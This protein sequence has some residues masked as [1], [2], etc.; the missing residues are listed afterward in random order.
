M[1]SEPEPRIEFSALWGHLTESMESSTTIRFSGE[2]EAIKLETI[3]L[4]TIELDLP[5]LVGEHSQVELLSLL[6]TGGMGQVHLGQQIAAQR[7]VAVKVLRPNA[8]GSEPARALLREALIHAR[9]QHP[10]IVPVYMVG[11]D[12]D[13]HPVIVMKKVDGTAWIDLLGDHDHP[14]HPEEDRLAGHLGILMQVCRAAHYA[15]SRG[16]VHRDIKPQNVMIGEFGEVYVLDWGLALP[17]SEGASQGLPTLE[18]ATTVSGTL[19]YM[20]PE[21]L[22]PAPWRVDPRTDVYLLGAVLHHILTGWPRHRGETVQQMLRA[23]YESSE[24]EFDHSVPSELAAI[25]NRATHAEKARRYESADALRRAI[26]DF[27]MHRESGRLEATAFQQLQNLEEAMLLPRADRDETEMYRAAQEA[28][29]GFRAA[30][31]SWPEN[32]EARVGLDDTLSTLI[33]WALEAGNLHSAKLLYTELDK[34]DPRLKHRI[35]RHQERRDQRDEE[36]ETLRQQAIDFDPARARGARGRLAVGLGA[37]W[38]VVPTSV[39]WMMVTG[40]IE[41]SYRVWS[42]SQ[43]VAWIVTLGMMVAFRKSLVL[44]AV[45]RKLMFALLA[46]IPALALGVGVSSAIGLTAL[47]SVPL[48]TVALAGACAVMGISIDPRL[49]GAALAYAVA[50]ALSALR[51]D[52]AVLLQGLGNLAALASVGLAWTMGKE[53]PVDAGAD[54]LRATA[55]LAPVA[56]PHNL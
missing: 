30:L 35:D 28:R 26:S 4:E 19:A 29:F 23:V 3:E 52:L 34:D 37:L 2:L 6:G 45:N 25:C 10:N 42:I 43:S 46:M 50:G 22:E 48:R 8:V 24:V 40:L 7:D 27:L 12:E 18:C 16:I 53:L 33:G 36:L 54:L 15:H 14:G 32:A 11:A 55:E 31:A 39:H 51:P 44:G 21:M 1:K 17:V 41:Y 9:L 20:A 47:Q 38:L 49:L 13:G 5:A 56:D